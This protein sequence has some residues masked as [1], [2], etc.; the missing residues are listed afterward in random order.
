MQA[1]QGN[2]A[3]KRPDIASERQACAVAETIGIPSTLKVA[4][5]PTQ[6]PRE[7]IDDRSENPALSKFS[8]CYPAFC[9]RN[10]L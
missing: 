9:R 10:F 8:C 6:V 4:P 3:E 2:A 1:G 5:Y 7:G